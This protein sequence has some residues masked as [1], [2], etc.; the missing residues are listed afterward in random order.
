MKKCDINKYIPASGVVAVV[1]IERKNVQ[2]QTTLR[3]YTN[4]KRVTISQVKF[5]KCSFML[6]DVIPH[7]EKLIMVFV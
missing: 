6:F 3:V 7:I 4:R 1:L 2:V 5:R